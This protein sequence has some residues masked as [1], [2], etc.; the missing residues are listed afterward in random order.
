[1]PPLT[2]VI[3]RP[4][5]VTRLVWVRLGFLPFPMSRSVVFPPG[6]VIFNLNTVGPGEGIFATAGGDELRWRFIGAL[7]A[8]LPSD[9]KWALN[10]EEHGSGIP[11]GRP[12]GVSE[13]RRDFMDVQNGG[14]VSKLLAH[15]IEL[16]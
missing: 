10:G 11:V 7:P 1:M 13:Y 5:R 3:D 4:L 8:D 9:M 15:L 14:N 6:R 16:K 2:I 12:P